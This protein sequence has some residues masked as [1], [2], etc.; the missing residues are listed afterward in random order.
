MST[1]S[2]AVIVGFAFLLLLAFWWQQSRYLREKLRVKMLY[3]QLQERNQEILRQNERLQE[4]DRLK[5][6]FLAR[7]SNETQSLLSLVIN[8][9]DAL[10]QRTDASLSDQQRA[11]LATIQDNSMRLLETIKQAPEPLPDQNRD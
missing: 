9:V 1:L 7:V 4:S 6:Q 10:L 2:L 5:S 8:L 3:N 11:D